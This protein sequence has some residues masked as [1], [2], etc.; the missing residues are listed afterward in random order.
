MFISKGSMK[1][2][3]CGKPVTIQ[4]MVIGVPDSD[5]NPEI[6]G[7]SVV[8]CTECE[9]PEFRM[10]RGTIEGF[11]I[12]CPPCTSMGVELDNNAYYNQSEPNP[13]ARIAVHIESGLIYPDVFDPRV[14]Y[15]NAG[16]PVNVFIGTSETTETGMYFEVELAEEDK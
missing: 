2:F 6:K 1:C 3:G 5:S 10:E 9:A 11:Y 7:L 12:G 13:S 15:G 14:M 8:M 4:N 16:D